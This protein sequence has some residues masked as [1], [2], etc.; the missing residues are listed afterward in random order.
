MNVVEFYRGGSSL[1][2][3]R[4]EVR[5]DPNTGLVQPLRGVSVFNRPDN[6]DRFG[7]PHRVTN[8]PTELQIVQRGHD[9]THFEIVPVQP[10]TFKE[11]E[12]ALGRIVLVPV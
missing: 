3:K 5:I 6:L 7:G 9:P 10:M 2:P 12:D 1:K 4:R 8:L 11:Y